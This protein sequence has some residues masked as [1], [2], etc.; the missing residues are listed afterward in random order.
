MAQANVITKADFHAK[1]LSLDRKITSNKKRDLL[2][3]NKLKKLEIFDSIYFR[4]KNQPIQKH[5]KTVSAND[6]NIL[7][8]KFKGLSDESIQPA[9]TSNKFLNT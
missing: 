3:E 4:G 7:S 2:I 6:S 9:T 8:W 1:L 5:F